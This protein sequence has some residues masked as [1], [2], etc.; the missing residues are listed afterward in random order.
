M[1]NHLDVLGP[2]FELLEGAEQAA[3]AAPVGSTI[4]RNYEA[5]L[6]SMR[7]ALGLSKKLDKATQD[8]AAKAYE[9]WKRDRRDRYNRQS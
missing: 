7:Y 1:T 9:D 2:M 8:R 6:E 4:R 5:S 3:A